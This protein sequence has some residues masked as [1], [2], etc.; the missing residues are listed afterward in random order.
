MPLLPHIEECL[1]DVR[2]V[3]RGTAA[4]AIGK[5]G[6]KDPEKWQEVLS[7]ALEKETDEEAIREMNQAI[8]LLQKK[9]P[10]KMTFYS[11]Y[12]I[13]TSV[14]TITG[15]CVYCINFWKMRNR[16]SQKKIQ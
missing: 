1:S 14:V 8:Q 3:I 5:L 4:W 11:K 2:P 16:I 6:I 13:C 15:F 7:C 10:K 9:N 12:I